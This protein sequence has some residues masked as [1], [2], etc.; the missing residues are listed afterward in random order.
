MARA[1]RR[2]HALSQRGRNVSDEVL[3]V[4]APA[5]GEG[6]VVAGALGGGTGTLF[7]SRRLL[8]LLFCELQGSPALPRLSLKWSLG[9]GE[10]FTMIWVKKAKT[11]LEGLTHSGKFNCF[12]RNLEKVTL[13]SAAP[14]KL[15]CEMKV[16]EQHANKIG[17]LHGGMTATLVDV[18][19]S[20]A[21]LCTERGISGVSVDMNITYISP[22]KV[23]ED[24]LITAHVLKEGRSLSFAS[25]DLTN[26]AT[27]KLIAQGRHTKHMGNR[28]FEGSVKKSNNECP[29]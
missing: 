19:S 8:T 3:D 18:I 24:I 7:G 29:E 21:L 16:E 22:A 5:A 27:G 14:G 10:R 20:L 15:V 28:P 17:T 25:V 4:S 2:V 12:D 26:K 9:T 6:T 1:K 13:V 11:L 23:G